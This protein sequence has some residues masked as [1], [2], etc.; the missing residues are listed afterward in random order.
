[1]ERSNENS[2]TINDLSTS[3]SSSSNTATLND[4]ESKIEESNCCMSIEDW[5]LLE[6]SMKLNDNHL[7]KMPSIKL[8]PALCD[9]DNNH[10]SVQENSGKKCTLKSRVE[11]R[12]DSFERILEQRVEKI[13]EDTAEKHPWLLPVEAWIVDRCKNRIEKRKNNHFESVSD[14]EIECNKDVNVKKICENSRESL[15]ESDT[16]F[17]DA[18]NFHSP[19]L[20][21]QIIDERCKTKNTCHDLLDKLRGGLKEKVEDVTR[22][23]YYYHFFFFFLFFLFIFFFVV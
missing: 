5:E 4:D 23:L 11:K 17:V 6:N 8:I 2:K 10:L 13:L 18:N 20:I 16:E 12:M 7:E 22:V 1:M 9:E 15:T 21:N 19:V 3:S 14:S